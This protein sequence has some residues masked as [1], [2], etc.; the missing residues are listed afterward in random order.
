MHY[1]VLFGIYPLLKMRLRDWSH[2]MQLGHVRNSVY[3]SIVHPQLYIH[4]RV[5]VTLV[6]HVQWSHE[7]S[8]KEEQ[9]SEIHGRSRACKK[10]SNKSYSWLKANNPHIY[11]HCIGQLQLSEYIYV[12]IKLLP[13]YYIRNIHMHNHDYNKHAQSMRQGKVYSF[14][15]SNYCMLHC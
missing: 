15:G 10:A 7:Y 6:L 2:A 13:P 14:I 8:P 11:R 3:I 9:I 1:R 12:I 4:T 5:T